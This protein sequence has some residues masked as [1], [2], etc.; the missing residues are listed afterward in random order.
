MLSLRLFRVLRY[1]VPGDLDGDDLSSVI[2][3]VIMWILISI[4]TVLLL[5]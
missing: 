2:V 1:K 5:G 4:F 3:S